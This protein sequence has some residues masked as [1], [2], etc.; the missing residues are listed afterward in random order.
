[1][2][3]KLQTVTVMHGVATCPICARSVLIRRESDRLAADQRCPHFRY[4][5]E[6]ERI[7]GVFAVV[8]ATPAAAFPQ[9]S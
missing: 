2:S 8:N 6:Y 4:A 5:A 3:E 1:M 9:R 7:Q